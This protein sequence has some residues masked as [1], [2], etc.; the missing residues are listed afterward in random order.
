MLNGESH[1]PPFHSAL[2][3]FIRQLIYLTTLATERHFGRA[4]K[5]CHVSQPALSDAIRKLEHELG[6]AI[7]QRT[8]RFEGFTTE[9]EQ[10]LLWARRILADCEAL[11]QAAQQPSHGL[12]GMIKLGAI[13]TALPLVP[14]LTEACRHI[15]QQI[16]HQVYTLAAPDILRKLATFELDIGLSYLDG[17]PNLNIHT[18]PLFQ[19]RYFL[20]AQ[21]AQLFWGNKTMSWAQAAQL[22]LCLLTPNM[23]SRHGI[24]G[25]FARAGFKAE[26]VLE[27]DSLT[28][29]CGHVQQLGLYSILPHSVFC[30]SHL[31]HSL[32]ALP[33]VPQLQRNIG[34][35]VRADHPHG[36]ILQAV[37][38]VFQVV[39]LQDQADA[40]LP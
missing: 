9:G 23:Q 8:Q 21:N 34:L 26:P 1:V 11:K 25:A 35:I 37:M 39:N 12:S 36:P 40:R 17:Q 6:V 29:L 2:V 19:E 24:D 20:V 4:A 7:V 22:P 3:M 27:S 16:R 31:T 38:Q 5:A 30:L 32:A 18:M 14:F 15:H 33:L 13:P 10:V 28:V